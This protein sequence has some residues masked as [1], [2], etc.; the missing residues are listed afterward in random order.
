MH[1]VRRGI[2]CYRCGKTGHV[3]R[4]CT[5]GATERWKPTG[6]ATGVKKRHDTRK[7][8]D[9]MDCSF[10]LSKEVEQ[11]DCAM[12]TMWVEVR[13]LQATL[14]TSCSQML[15]WVGTIP[16][17][18]IEWCPPVRMP[19]IHGE[20]EQ[21]ERDFVDMRIAGCKGK[22][23]IGLAPQLDGQMIVVGDCP[24]LYEV[25]EEVCAEDM[26]HRRWP[27]GEGWIAEGDS[28][29][30]NE[31]EWVSLRTGTKCMHFW[32]AQEQDDELW[33]IRQM[34]AAW[35]KEETV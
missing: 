17:R 29:A 13:L 19:C 1:Q 34:E 18:V 14:D 12:V 11:W 2:I 15:I 4:E 30:S 33:R 25:L 9:E 28:A 7:P 16:E 31:E 21:Y 24:P 20:M 10:G 35:V 26:K 3:S 27:C 23:H 32:M 8:I 5:L 6:E 22:L